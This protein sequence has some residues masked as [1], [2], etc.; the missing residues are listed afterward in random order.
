MSFRCHECTISESLFKSERTHI[1][2][3]NPKSITFDDGPAGSDLSG[4][5]SP[6]VQSTLRRFK[7]STSISARSSAATCLQWLNLTFA[8]SM[9]I[10]K[11]CAFAFKPHFG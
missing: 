1:L 5:L 8:D 6:L 2:G 10:D 3:F 4:D 11:S 9:A 7:R